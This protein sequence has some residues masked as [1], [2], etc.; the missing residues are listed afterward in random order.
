MWMDVRASEEAARIE[1][2]GDPALKYSGYSAVSAEW[3]LPKVLWLKETEREAYDGA[4]R[5]C[6]CL[7]VLRGGRD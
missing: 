1:E 2:P 4:G 6:D 3:C 7:D 5:V